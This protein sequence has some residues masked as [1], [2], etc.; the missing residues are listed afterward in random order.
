MTSGQRAHDVLDHCHHLVDEA[1]RSLL[2]GRVGLALYDMVRY[3]L[4]YAGPD[5]RPAA[6]S[7]G[8]RIR[9]ALCLVSCQA[10]GGEAGWAAPAAA[11]IEFLHNSTLL[12]DNIADQD[13]LRR[14]RPS[15][16]RLWGVGQAISAGDSMLG[17]AN[18]AMAA[19]DQHDVPPAV[20]ISALRQLNQA[21]VEVCEGQHLDLSYEGRADIAVDDYLRMIGLKTSPLLRSA[22]AIGAEIGR[23]PAAVVEAFGSFGA[24]LGLAYQI[25]DD[26]LGLW[27]DPGPM[28][29]PVGSDLRQNKRSLPIVL[30]LNRGAP[31]LRSRLA[32]ALSR[33]I[34]GEEEA[35]ALASEIEAAGLR[36][37]CEALAREHLG[38]ALRH[39]EGITL[40][41][42]PAADLRD[43][44]S[45]LVERDR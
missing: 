31:A 36:A 43:L 10:A 8:K 26:I 32:E 30:A 37:A 28:G 24:D 39:L 27:G 7:V 9:S 1:V 6:A 35:A 23:A 18:L 12:H 19:L 17:L 16:W 11:A 3:H 20:V 40:V 33:G 22:A 4:G 13:E 29:K 34:A 2:A 45:Y 21:F 42:G 5:G 41:P 25:R 38:R 14:G 15:V 44:A